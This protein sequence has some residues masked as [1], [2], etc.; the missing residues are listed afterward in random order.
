MYALLT[1]DVARAAVADQFSYGEPVPDAVTR[2]GPAPSAPRTRFAL[3]G[4]LHRLA[5]TLAP[6][7]C[8]TAR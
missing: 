7:E 4:L 8:S 3:S 2:E 5:D 6:A 1:L